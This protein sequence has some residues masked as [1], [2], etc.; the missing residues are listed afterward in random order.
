MPSVLIIDDDVSVLRFVQRV[1]GEANRP[2][3]TART[4][5]DG[6]VKL[7]E[8]HPDVL[9]LNNVLPDANGMELALRVKQFDNKLP[10]VVLIRE[11]TAR[12]PSKR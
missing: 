11:S 3:V 7:R 12:P 4:A 1:L 8:V 5:A 6:L 10:I 2:V 9:F